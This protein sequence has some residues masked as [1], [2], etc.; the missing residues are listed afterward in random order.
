MIGTGYATS[1]TMVPSW[2]GVACRRRLRH[3]DRCWTAEEEERGEVARENKH[4]M[5]EEEKAGHILAG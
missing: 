5:D 2:C 1:L 3:P 4:M